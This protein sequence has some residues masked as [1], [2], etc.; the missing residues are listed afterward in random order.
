MSL[1]RQ[2]WLLLIATVLLALAGSVTVNV[3][4]TRE[5]LETQLRMK[6]ND[7]AASLALALSQQKG[8]PELMAL[9]MAAQFDTGFYRR[10]QFIDA[11]GNVAFDRHADGKPRQAPAWFARWVPVQSDPGL[12]Q[13]SDGWRALG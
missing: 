10:I 6:N 12:G 11:L 7:N 1:I 8:D 4:S 9:L 5:T 3:V 2:V 13:V